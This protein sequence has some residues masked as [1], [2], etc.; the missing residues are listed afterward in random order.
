MR[1]YKL[2]LDGYCITTARYN[3]LLSFCRLYD[4]RMQRMSDTMSLSSP[5]FD[6]PVQGG[7]PSDPTLIKATKLQKLRADNAIIDACLLEA[8][9]NNERAANDLKRNV[10][11]RYGDK[12]IGVTSIGLATMYRYRTRFFVLLDR[13]LSERGD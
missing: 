1:E 9:Y 8:A 13:A 2:H 11:Y 6:A 10:I 5:P 3:Y 7:L 4:E 12:R